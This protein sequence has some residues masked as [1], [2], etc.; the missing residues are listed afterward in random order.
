MLAIGRP[1]R[2]PLVPCLQVRQ[3]R[4][5]VAGERQ[6]EPAV[7]HRPHRNVAHGEIR[8]G[9]IGPARQ[10]CVQ[11]RPDRRG[12]RPGRVD[13]RIV[14]LFRRRTDQPPEQR[15]HAGHHRGGLP[16]HP[17]I[18]LPARAGIGGPQRA[19]G[20]LGT[21]IPDNRVALPQ[22]VAVIVDGR[23][24]AVRIHRAVPWLVV[25]AKRPADIGAL[26]G[27]A[28]FISG[29]QR[30]LH[31]DRIGAAVD[32]QHGSPPCS[33]TGSVARGKL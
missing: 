14:A 22:R 18:G 11:P 10:M 1:L 6:V 13:R 12:G 4:Q 28:A 26:E 5:V 16:V 32:F 30:L 7:A 23:H 33:P 15:G 2:Q 9:D 25:S 21:Q 24:D 27:H 20:M 29:P 8:P 17:A 31:V 3:H 19:G